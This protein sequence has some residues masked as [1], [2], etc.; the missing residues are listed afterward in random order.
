MKTQAHL[1]APRAPGIPTGVKRLKRILHCIFMSWH[2]LQKYYKRPLTISISSSPSTL[3]RLSRIR[4]TDCERRYGLLTIYSSI[5]YL[6][7][8]LAEMAGRKTTRWSRVHSEFSH[9]CKGCGSSGVSSY[10]LYQIVFV[11][12]SSRANSSNTYNKKRALVSRSR[13]L[14][15]LSLNLTQAERAMNPFTY[16]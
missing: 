15:P 16:I 5:L 2:H 12:L 7:W 6:T 8:N 4:R 11:S 14:G 10:V 1:S 13:E 3:G 9:S